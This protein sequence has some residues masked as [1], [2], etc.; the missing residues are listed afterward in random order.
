MSVVE[1]TK[2]EK[3]NRARITII[4]PKAPMETA[5]LVQGRD[6]GSDDFVLILGDGTV[7]ILKDEPLMIKGSHLAFAGSG[8]YK[9]GDNNTVYV[10][11]D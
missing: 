6:F 11:V 4:P 1:E 5:N 7:I 9:I 3:E 8:R 10:D 2:T